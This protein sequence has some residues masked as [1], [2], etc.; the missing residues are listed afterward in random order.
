LSL[1]ADDALFQGVFG[2]TTGA[3]EQPTRVH[4][5]FSF[6]QGRICGDCNSGWM[7]RL[8][9]IAKPIVEPLVDER[10]SLESLNAF[11][12]A[13]LAKWA[14]KTAYMHTWASPLKQPVQ[15]AHLQAL[16]DDAGAPAPGVAVFGM[17]SLYGR[18]SSYIQTGHWPQLAL[19]PQTPPSETP[20]GAYKIG[21]QFRHLYLLVAFWP[22]EPVAFTLVRAMHRRLF[23]A[24][25]GPDPDYSPTLVI[26]D[27]PVDRLK[28]FA[29]WLAVLHLKPAV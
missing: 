12:A 13:T 29:D 19:P 26:C 11:E 20:A 21:L 27:G 25:D 23:P 28:A 18:P 14:V 16:R 7:S 9:T 24:A 1:P 22:T 2:S 4:S 8:E 3:L 5:T 6:V 17:Q 15:L 10:R